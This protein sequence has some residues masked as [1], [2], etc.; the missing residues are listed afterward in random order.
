MEKKRYG[1]THQMNTITFRKRD[2]LKN[3]GFDKSRL[4]EGERKVRGGR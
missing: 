1:M 4:R 2:F 3:G